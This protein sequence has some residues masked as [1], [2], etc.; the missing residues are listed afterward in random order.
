M[1]FRRIHEDIAIKGR[2][3]GLCMTMAIVQHESNPD[4]FLRHFCLS[5]ALVKP[6]YNTLHQ[7]IQPSSDIHGLELASTLQQ[8][9][10]NDDSFLSVGALMEW[11]GVHLKGECLTLITINGSVAALPISN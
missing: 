3:F 10:T 9:K 11:V 5:I 6:S 2:R 8:K 7:L 1:L 4:A